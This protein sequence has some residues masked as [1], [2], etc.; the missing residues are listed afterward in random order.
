LAEEESYGWIFIDIVPLM[1]DKKSVERQLKIETWLDLYQ[2]TAEL[3]IT[4]ESVK[5]NKSTNQLHKLRK[6]DS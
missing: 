5:K 1:Y 2:L 4:K 6:A 3:N